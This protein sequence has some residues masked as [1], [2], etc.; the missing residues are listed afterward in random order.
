MTPYSDPMRIIIAAIIAVCG[1]IVATAKDAAPLPATTQST[2][3]ALLSIDQHRA[4]VVDRIVADWS[5]AFAKANAGID[6]IQLRTLLQGMRADY[7]LAASL[8]GTLDGLRRKRLS[9]AVWFVPLVVFAVIYLI[10]LIRIGTYTDATS[11][12]LRIFVLAMEGLFISIGVWLVRAWRKPGFVAL[13]RAGVYSRSAI[14]PVLVPWET[15]T[16]AGTHKLAGVLSLGLCTNT[17]PRHAPFWMRAN[18]PFQRRFTGW[19]FTYPLPVIRVTSGRRPVQ[20]ASVG[21]PPCTS[22]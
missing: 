11:N 9:Q 14:G 2:P 6:A 22:S 16:K 3:N 20:V 17:T 13:L 4:T 19:D 10:L 18:R 12:I 15:I 8:A 5:D 1:S 7:L 21:V